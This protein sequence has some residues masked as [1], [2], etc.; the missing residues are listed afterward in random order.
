MAAITAVTGPPENPAIKRI[1]DLPSNII[2]GIRVM[3]VIIPM[4]E[5]HPKRRPETIL[6]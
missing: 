4:I 1:M 3:G 6:K 2:P 5:T